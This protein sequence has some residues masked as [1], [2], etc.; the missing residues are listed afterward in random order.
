MTDPLAL[1]LIE[2]PPYFAEHA[3][4]QRDRPL[5]VWGRSAPDSAITVA[6]AGAQ[7]AGRTDRAGCFHVE[8]PALPAGGPY[9][10]VVTSGQAVQRISDILIGEVWL[11]AGQ[12][13]MVMELWRSQGGPAEVTNAAAPQVRCFAVTRL[14]LPGGVPEAGGTWSVC[15]PAHAGAWPA[16]GYHA[17]CELQRQL[18]VPVGIIAAAWGG[19]RIATW[20]SRDALRAEPSTRDELTR[21]EAKLATADAAVRLADLWRRQAEPVA[22]ERERAFP[23]PGNGVLAQ[24]W[25][26]G[27]VGDAWGTMTIPG[28]WIQ[29]GLVRSGVVWFRREVEIPAAWAGRDLELSLGTVD[30][31]DTTY[32]AGAEI[33]ATGWEQPDAWL[34]PRNYRIPGRLVSAGR[35]VLAVRA[36]SW[37]Y[38]GGLTGP[39]EVMELRCGAERLP[40]AG[41]WRWRMEHDYGPQRRLQLGEDAFKHDDPAVLFESMLAPL[42]AV[43]LAGALWYQGESDTGQAPHYHARFVALLRALRALWGEELF[44]AWVQL[45]GHLPMGS[46]PELSGWAEIREAQARALAEPRS[47]MVS[48]VDVGD[49]R[50]IHPRDKRP[51]GKRLA[52]AVLNRHYG[53]TEFPA[54]GPRLAA[55]R[56]GDAA[57]EVRFSGV[58][59]GLVSTGE[60][61]PGF[62][63]AGADGAS[64]PAAAR[65]AG[66]DLVL[67]STPPGI[68]PRELR[69]AWGDCPQID[70]HGSAGLPA[71]PFRH[72]LAGR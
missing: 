22:W 36:V 10:L 70:L 32:F 71:E 12:S 9:E 6:L 46:E 50:D 62:T 35:Q 25:A 17:A 19:T 11:L 56:Q 63:I 61:L 13:N 16:V 3:V 7:V 26:A 49:P 29:Q 59:R 38:D 66:P 39:A 54:Q 64:H 31:H 28:S 65:I 15:D 57:I 8:L 30:K 33:G 72:P 69:Y 42:R 67:V 44:I 48:A 23:D 4:L 37:W 14:A 21:H 27:E 45:A 52:W 18:G 51:V 5:A 34:T 20:L 53:R 41:A 1:P 40:L 47:A 24:G 43:T 68:A 2:L 60:A 55:I 58:G